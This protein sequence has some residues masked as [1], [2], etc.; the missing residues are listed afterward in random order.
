MT[1]TEFLT[2]RLDERE[3]EHEGHDFDY[4][5]LDSGI[6]LCRHSSHSA[7]WSSTCPR[8]TYSALIRA[9]IAAQRRIVAMAHFSDDPEG[10]T[11]VD[12]WLDDERKHLSPPPV[13]ALL[14]AVF[15]ALVG[16][17]ADHPDFQEDWRA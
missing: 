10:P 5:S 13:H 1:I 12:F 11:A 17:F 14:I 15:L 4:T 16:Q 2:A 6:S 7:G 9:D 8:A 3:R